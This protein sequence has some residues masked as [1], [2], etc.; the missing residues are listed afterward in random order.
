M[1]FDLTGGIDIQREYICETCPQT[2]GTRDAVN[3]WLENLDGAFAMRIGIEALAPQWDAHELW[4]DIAFAD[5][6]VL[7]ARQFGKT[8]PAIG[9]EGLP[10]VR[11]AGPVRFHCVEPFRTW[12]VAFSGHAEEITTANLLEQNLPA[13]PAATEVDFDIQMN[14]AAPPWMPGSLLSDAGKILSTRVEGEF[15]SP[16][17]EQLFRASG[18]LRIGGAQFD[19]DANGLRIRRQGV[20]KFEGFWGHCWQSALFPSGR[21][22]GFNTY[23]PVRLPRRHGHRATTGFSDRSASTRTLSLERRGDRR[24]DRALHPREQGHALTLGADP[25][26]TPF[27][28][29]SKAKC[30]I[31]EAPIDEGDS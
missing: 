2:P 24:H 15:M 8:H 30:R 27:R 17:Y 22:F 6:R 5:G 12:T 11:G 7:Q 23:P 9:P 29:T 4:L 14:M 25:F 20:R 1:A 28:L 21:A 31:F 10:T 13:K 16:R 3:V 26:V 18:R 19:V